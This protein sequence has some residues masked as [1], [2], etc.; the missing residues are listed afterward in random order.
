MQDY[1]YCNF[2]RIDDLREWGYEYKGEE[3]KLAISYL[4]TFGMKSELATR[5]KKVLRDS[6]AIA[7]NASWRREAMFKVYQVSPFIFNLIA[8]AVGKMKLG[9]N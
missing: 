3:A 1:F 4:A 8:I 7:K 5:C 9:H 6:G 2:R